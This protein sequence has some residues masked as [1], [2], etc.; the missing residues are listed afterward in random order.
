[1]DLQ[2]RFFQQQHFLFLSFFLLQINSII[3]KTRSNASTTANTIIAPKDANISDAIAA[4]TNSPTTNA[5]AT[6]IITVIIPKH[7]LLL[8]LSSF[9]SQQNT[10]C[11]SIKVTSCITHLF[12]VLYYILCQ[13]QRKDVKFRHF[14]INVQNFTSCFLFRFNYYPFSQ[15]SFLMLFLLES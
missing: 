10:S 14:Y 13:I 5:R 11:G 3:D 7:L 1:M 15:L 4:P 2:S 8:H 12:D 9:L 6:A